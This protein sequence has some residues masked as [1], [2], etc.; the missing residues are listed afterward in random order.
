MYEHEFA[1]KYRL[2]VFAILDDHNTRKSH[3]PEGNLRAFVQE[4]AS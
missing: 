1:R 2:L 4:S 3:N